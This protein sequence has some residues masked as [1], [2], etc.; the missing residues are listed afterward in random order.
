MKIKEEYIKELC[1]LLPEMPTGL[2]DTVK[3]IESLID[4]AN[5]ELREN[6]YDPVN[7]TSKRVD[8]MR[9]HAKKIE[10]E[11]ERRLGWSREVDDEEKT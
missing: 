10:C 6:T 3:L 11:M 4:L 9:N 1:L 2:Y 7:F 5:E 8:A